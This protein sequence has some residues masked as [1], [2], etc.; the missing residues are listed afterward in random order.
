M[1]KDII[2]WE[3][4]CIL[5]GACCGAYDGDPCEQ[6]RRDE[7]GSYYCA[8]YENRLGIHHTIGGK[9]LEC[10]PIKKKLEED[11]V[12]DHLCAY[13]RLISEEE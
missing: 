1:E 9:E 13:K 4:L 12:G 6:L 5:C 2:Y 10:I 3:D 8:D 11:W 7:D